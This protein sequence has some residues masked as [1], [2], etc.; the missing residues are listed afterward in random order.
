MHWLFDIHHIF[1]DAD[2]GFAELMAALE[3]LP[4]L[5]V[6]LLLLEAKLDLNCKDSFHIALRAFIDKYIEDLYIQGTVR[7][8]FHAGILVL[9]F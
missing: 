4:L 1:F 7:F 6:K 8:L 2:K 9:Y 5:E 3:R